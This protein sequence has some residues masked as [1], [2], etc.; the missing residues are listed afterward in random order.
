MIS[1]EI[2]AYIGTATNAMKACDP[3]E[4]GAVRRFAQA[5]MDPDPSYGADCEENARFRGPV[6]PPLYPN[7]VARRALGEPDP[8]QERGEDPDFDGL[9][10]ASG[11]PPIEPLK[12]L[13]I[14]N[15]GSE[16]ELFRYARHG[17]QLTVVERYVDITAKQ[18]SKGLMYLVRIESEFRGGDGELIMRATRTQIRR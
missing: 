15:G 12:H 11:L 16:F 17:E 2:K 9:V 13:G 1:D 8:I 7:H 14:L 6:A 10:L 5:V 18:S 4:S 3:V